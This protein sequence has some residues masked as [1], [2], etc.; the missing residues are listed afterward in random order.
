[1]DKITK[2]ILVEKNKE[3][4]KLKAFFKDQYKNSNKLLKTIRKTKY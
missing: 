2:Y 1:M 3:Y 4:Q